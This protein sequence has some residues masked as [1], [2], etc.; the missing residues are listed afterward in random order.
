MYVFIYNIYMN[1]SKNYILL[2]KE[3]HS[4]FL[5][6][7]QVCVCIGFV[8]FKEYISCYENNL[9]VASNFHL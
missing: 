6:S 1:L 8:N 3:T 4:L 7:T 9:L 2:N 5:T